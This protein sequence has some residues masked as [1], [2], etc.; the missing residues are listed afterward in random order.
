MSSKKIPKARLVTKDENKSSRIAQ[1]SAF[2]YTLFKSEDVSM[3]TQEKEKDISELGLG[4]VSNNTPHQ[5]F[6]P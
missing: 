1:V 4:T 3:V 6:S 2:E 5:T